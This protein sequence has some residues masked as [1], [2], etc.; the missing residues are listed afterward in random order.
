M[1]HKCKITVIRREFFQDLADEYLADPNVG[2]CSLFHDGQEFI[3][4]QKNFWK[5]MNA[6]FAQKHG[7]ASAVMSMQPCKVARS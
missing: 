6:S 3:V 7:T 1:K 2:K 5:M 4:D